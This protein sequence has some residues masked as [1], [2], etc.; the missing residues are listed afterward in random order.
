[1]N[2]P[3]PHI[4]LKDIRALPKVKL[5]LLSAQLA[6]SRIAGKW[7][8]LL[9]HPRDNRSSS[10]ITLVNHNHHEG[11]NSKVNLRNKYVKN[12]LDMLRIRGSLL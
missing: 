1:M 4:H 5:L 10:F 8:N 7:Y 2:L 6:R 12:Q 11:R 9:R 3:H